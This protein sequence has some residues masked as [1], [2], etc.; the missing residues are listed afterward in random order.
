MVTGA[1]KFAVGSLPEQDIANRVFDCFVMQIHWREPLDWNRVKRNARAIARMNHWWLLC[2][3]TAVILFAGCLGL[4]IVH[5][6][7]AERLTGPVIAVV[8]CV[9][10]IVFPLALFIYALRA[11]FVRF[12]REAVDLCD[13]SVYLNPVR[14]NLVDWLCEI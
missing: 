9:G 10:M 8:S 14:K 6:S 7:Y 3:G 11:G 4:R 12:R 5:P 13:F 2:G 1:S